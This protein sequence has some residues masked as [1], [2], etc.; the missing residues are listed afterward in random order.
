MPA[1]A[2]PAAMPSSS[3]P[4]VNRSTTTAASDG[5]PISMA[6]IVATDI[7]ISMLNGEPAWAKPDGPAAEEPQAEQGRRQFGIGAVRR[8][9]CELPAMH[10]RS[11]RAADGQRQPGRFAHLATRA[12]SVASTVAG[13]AESDRADDLQRLDRAATPIAKAPDLSLDSFRRGVASLVQLQEG[14]PGSGS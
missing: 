3:W 10:P 11:S 6:P 12:R 7:S 13:V 1:R 8:A 5:A 14:Q 9:A 4:A 2:R